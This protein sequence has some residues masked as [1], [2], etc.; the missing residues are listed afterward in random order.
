LRALDE[1]GALVEDIVVHRPSLDDV[2]ATLTGVAP[3]PDEDEEMEG[4]A[5]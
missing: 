2:F 3:N 1:V 4:A 5:A